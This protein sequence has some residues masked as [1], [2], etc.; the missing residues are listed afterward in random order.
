MFDKWIDFN[1]FARWFYVWDYPIVL[2]LIR[3]TKFD[4][5]DYVTAVYT[6][7]GES[8]TNT[9]S[10]RKRWIMIW[11]QMKIRSY[12]I[13]K[14]GCKLSTASYVIYKFTRDVISV[15]LKRWTKN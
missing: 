1:K 5:I 15:I 13:L 2:E 10:R 7:E 11:G 12:Y 8:K 6:V 4:Q 9:R 14:Y 3:R